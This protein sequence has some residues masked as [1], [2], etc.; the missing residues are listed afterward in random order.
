[1]FVFV[2][3]QVNKQKSDAGCVA[4]IKPETKSKIKRNENKKK[5]TKR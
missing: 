1:M 2:L 5:I 3:K 4:A